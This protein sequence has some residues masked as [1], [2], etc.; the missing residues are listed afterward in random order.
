MSFEHFP[1]SNFHELNADWLLREVE[2]I[3]K[4]TYGIIDETIKEYID[5]RFNNMMINAIYD[6]ETETIYL[7]LEEKEK[8]YG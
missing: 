7:R 3:S 6:A 1:Y 2:R 4:L 5:N 8:V